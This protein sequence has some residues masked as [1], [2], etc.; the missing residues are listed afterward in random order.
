MDIPTPTDDGRISARIAAAA[1][2][3]ARLL[4]HLPEAVDELGDAETAPTAHDDRRERVE[5]TIL[6]FL[7]AVDRGD[8][9]TIRELL[10][11]DVTYRSPGRSRVSGVHV[12]AD[13]VCSVM[14]VLPRP[15][16]NQ[17]RTERIHLFVDGEGG[18]SFHRL[19]GRLDGRSVSYELVLRLAVGDGLVEEITELTGDQYLADDVFGA[20]P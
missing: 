10:H 17:L 14:Q 20:T 9:E 16:A 3:L 12:G 8:L 11:P 1:S 2:E 7:D 18:A 6:A 5:K 4:S 13:A 19:S 15:G